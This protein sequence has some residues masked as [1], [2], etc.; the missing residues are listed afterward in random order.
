MQIDEMRLMDIETRIA[1]QDDTIQKLNDVVT[2]QQRQIDGL[3][4]ML[5]EMRA[6]LQDV[7]AG[8]DQ[9]PPREEK[10]PHY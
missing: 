1:Y 6:R 2:R 3:Q 8:A 10:P 9:V 4:T 7:L 5:L